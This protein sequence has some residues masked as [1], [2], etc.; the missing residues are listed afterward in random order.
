MISFRISKELCGSKSNMR[1]IKRNLQSLVKTK[2]AYVL[3]MTLVYL[4]YES[5]HREPTIS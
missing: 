2:S 1:I 5:V 4:K 3:N